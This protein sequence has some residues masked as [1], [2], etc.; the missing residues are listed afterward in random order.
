M[1]ARRSAVVRFDLRR[2]RRIVRC[3][4]CPRGPWH[5]RV[6]PRAGVSSSPTCSPATTSSSSPRPARARRSPSASRSSI[7]S[8]RPTAAPSAL[9]L[10]PTRELASQIVDELMSL[11]H[12]RALGIA[13]VYGGV[14]IER[15]AKRAKNAHIIVATPGRLEDLIDRG[16]VR[17]TRQAARA[18]RGRPHARHGLP[19]G[20]R[21]HRRSSPASARRCSSRRRSRGGRPA[22]RRATPTPRART[23]RC[24]PRS[25]RARSSTASSTSPTRPRSIASSRSCAAPSA[26]A[27]SSSCAP[28]AAPT[29]WSSAWAAT[30]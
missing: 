4:A 18:R 17:S 3:R 14:G 13:A 8:P 1:A 12:A 20:R 10:A 30:T 29:G 21:P 24:T 2:S 11:A 5:H 19:P 7:A 23:R 15:Q 27:R 25:P 22:G 28:S 6:V 9:I 16:D 26:A